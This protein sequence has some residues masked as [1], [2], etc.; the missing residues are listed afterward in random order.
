M[1][2]KSNN[3]ESIEFEKKNFSEMPIITS[4]SLPVNRP[5]KA[6]DKDKLIEKYKRDKKYLEENKKEK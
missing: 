2:I 3:E 6:K 5:L 1:P 4:S